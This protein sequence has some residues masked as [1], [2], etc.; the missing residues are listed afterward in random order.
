MVERHGLLGRKPDLLNSTVPNP[1]TWSY[2]FGGNLPAA[3]ATL[4]GEGIYLISRSTDNAQNVEFPANSIPPG[5]GVTVN[6]DFDTPVSSVTYPANNSFKHNISSYVGTAIETGPGTQSG[7]STV[8]I[9]IRRSNGDYWNGSAFASNSGNPIWVTPNVFV[10]SWTY[11]SLSSGSLTPNVSYIIYSIP[12]DNAGNGTTA[13]VTDAMVQA[14]GNAFMF[15]NITPTSLT[16]LP[17]NNT[18]LSGFV[19]SLSGTASDPSGSGAATV[20]IEV[21]N[22]LGQ[23]Y[24]W[25]TGFDATPGFRQP[26]TPVAGGAWSANGLNAG[27]FLEGYQ[28]QVVTQAVDYAGN[29]ETPYTTTTFVV[30]RSSPTSAITYPG[31]GGYVSQTGF[32]Q[33]TSTDVLVGGN[34]PAGISKVKV[35]ISTNSFNSFWTGSSWTANRHI[36]HLVECHSFSQRDR[37]VA[38]PIALGYERHIRG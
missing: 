17:A 9:A 12:I 15:D 27:H 38:P 26:F 4:S 37:L 1:N 32:A 13:G 31:A 33:G 10:S 29:F 18:Y 8:Q 23:Y 30:D 21:I 24:N 2:T 5:A 25:L 34:F 16:T 19:T 7:L 6:L 14:N 22:N 3:I 11:L 35:R 28:Y 36:Q 20:N